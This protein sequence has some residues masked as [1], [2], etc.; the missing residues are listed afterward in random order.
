M[1]NLAALALAAF[2]ALVLEDTLF[3]QVPGLP[4]VPDVI[5]VLVVYLAMYHH[6]VHGVAVAFFLG[7]ALD[8]FSGTVF[9]MNAFALMVVYMG[10]YL[11]ARTLQTEGGVPTMAV[12]F[13]AALGRE[14]ALALGST[15]LGDPGRFWER[16]SHRGLLDAGVAALVAP[17]VFAFV[18]WEKRAVGR[19]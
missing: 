14:A 17:L 5:L 15:L 9:G 4:V 18:G 12:V 16:L 7:Y 1:R 10:V 6:G 11:V 8:T 2:V 3:S 13:V 19:A